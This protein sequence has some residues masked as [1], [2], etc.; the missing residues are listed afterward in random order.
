MGVPL[1]QRCRLDKNPFHVEGS[2]RPFAE[3]HL[4]LIIPRDWNLFVDEIPLQLLK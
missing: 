3:Q 1:N 4:L 2:L